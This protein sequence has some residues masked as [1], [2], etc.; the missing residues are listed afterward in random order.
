MGNQLDDQDIKNFL[1]VKR[2]VSLGGLKLVSDS[3]IFIC[4]M[5]MLVWSQKRR[6]HLS[7]AAD[8][9]VGSQEL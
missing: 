8:V 2:R 5:G 9:A 7:S 6:Y 1:S 3:S 4:W